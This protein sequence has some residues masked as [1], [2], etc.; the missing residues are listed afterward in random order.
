MEC[1][2]VLRGM[3]IFVPIS[4]HAAQLLESAVYTSGRVVRIRSQFTHGRNKVQTKEKLKWSKMRGGREERPGHV[5]SITEN[6]PP[7]AASATAAADCLCDP[8]SLA[9][10]NT[11]KRRFAT[12]V[13]ACAAAPPLSPHSHTFTLSP[14]VLFSSRRRRVFALPFPPFTREALLTVARSC[15]PECRCPGCRM[16]G[17]LTDRL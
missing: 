14:V 2:D 7:R 3:A 12:V 17:P 1:V 5:S 16:G 13:S 4:A 11:T 6:Q 10:R 9:P 15:S 8:A